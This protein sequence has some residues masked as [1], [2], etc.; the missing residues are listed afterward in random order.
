MLVRLTLNDLKLAIDGTIIMSENLR[1]ALDCMYDGKVPNSWSKVTSRN[2]FS[3]HSVYTHMF[4]ADSMHT[5]YSTCRFHGSRPP[6]GSG[7]LIWLK[8]THSLAHGALRADLS[9]FG[10]LAFSTLKVNAIYYNSE[11][12]K[13]K[14]LNL[15]VILEFHYK[16][17]D[18]IL[19]TLLFFTKFMI[20]Q[21][22]SCNTFDKS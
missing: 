22:C 9:P 15:N 18:S 8:G 10:W 13:Q 14:M 5:S 12:A 21:M 11:L 7:L 4:L 1:D 20:Y 19:S 17:L 3:C 2:L 16:F 6:L